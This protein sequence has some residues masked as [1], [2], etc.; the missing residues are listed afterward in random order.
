MA[1]HQ[2]ILIGSYTHSIGS[3]AGEGE[4]IYSVDFNTKTG[5]FS[6]LELIPDL[7][8][9]SYLAY[10]NQK[11]IAIHEFATE[12]GAAVSAFN[13]KN[14]Q[15]S[16]SDNHLIDG[17]YP[18]HVEVNSNCSLIV[19]SNYGSGNFSLFALKKDQ[20]EHIHTI[21]HIGHGPNTERQEAPHAHFACFLK[22]SKE[23]VTVDLGIDRVSFY[24]FDE[25]H[26]YESDAQYIDVPPGSGPRHLIF[27]KNERTAY[28]LCELSEKILV[29]KKNAL[30]GWEIKSA[31]SPF[32]K[33]TKGGASAAIRLSPDENFVYASGRNQS[34]IVCLKVEKE[35]VL[36]VVQT[37][38]SGGINP[39]DFNITND[40]HW[41]IV[42]NQDTNNLVS[43]R[44]NIENGILEA[45][46][47][48][49]SIGNPVCVQFYNPNA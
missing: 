15:I 43:Y 3:M 34:C 28:V 4:G 2:G 9:P 40:G 41:L 13:F 25:S 46:E 42:A 36:A 29:L 18:C 10:K 14:K 22:H 47:H 45:T 38:S 5:A 44:R 27:S 11:V 26:V 20:L 32:E 23:I 6:H 39:R 16:Q 48:S 31:V 8:N 21:Q 37:I 24:P 12:K 1:N 17:D 35:G 30:N 19:T 33:H 49:I 7:H